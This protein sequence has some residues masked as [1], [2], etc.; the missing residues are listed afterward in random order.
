MCDKLSAGW[1]E[2]RRGT[3]RKTVDLG[4]KFSCNLIHHRREVL[5]VSTS[6]THY[7]GLLHLT[8]PSQ[9]EMWATRL[10]FFFDRGQKRERPSEFN[11]KIRLFITKTLIFVNLGWF[12]RCSKVLCYPFAP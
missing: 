9:S 12:T 8:A 10:P 3:I 6:S 5:S 4:I 11:G 2:D 1:R 7:N